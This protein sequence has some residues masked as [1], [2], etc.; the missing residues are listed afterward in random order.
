MT[1]PSKMPMDG[2][3]RVMQIFSP[4]AIVTVTA[5]EAYDV[6]ANKVRAFRVGAD[7]TYHI[8]S[9]SD[10]VATILAGLSTGVG[11]GVTTITFGTTAEIEI[12]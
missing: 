8:N 1:N 7:N 6:G 2:H 5:T 4:R 9:D 11:T 12:M 10:H 3:S